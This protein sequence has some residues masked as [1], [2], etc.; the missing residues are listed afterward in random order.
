MNAHESEK[1]VVF[2]M[3]ATDSTEAER[4][5]IHYVIG[6]FCVTCYVANANRLRLFNRK[7][8]VPLYL[9]LG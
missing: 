7:V 6:Y 9:G 3:N 5:V 8:Q 1:K 4:E 2:N